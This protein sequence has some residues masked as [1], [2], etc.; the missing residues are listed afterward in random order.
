MNTTPTIILIGCGQMGSAIVRGLC[1]S[2]FDPRNLVVVDVDEERERALAEELGARAGEDALGEDDTERVYLMAVKPWYIQGVLYARDFKPRDQIIS[3][4]AGVTTKDMREW[5][6]EGPAIIRTMP[7]TPCLVGAGVTGIFAERGTNLAAAHWIFSRV[8]EVVELGSESHFDALTAISG[9]GPAYV[10]TILEALA[11]G[12]V[13]MGLDRATARALALGT[14]AGA[15]KL[16]SESEEH[17]AELKD[18]VTSPGGATIAAL[19]ELE[20]GNIR[21]TLMSAVE[22]AARRNKALG[23][24]S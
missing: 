4:A 18:R 6:G 11:D 14:L 9:C 16:A 20:R 1:A 2:D 15:T 17:T 23:K 7:N 24:K 12:G 8:G 22:A 10:F 5:V 13:M 3:V 21:H 19:R